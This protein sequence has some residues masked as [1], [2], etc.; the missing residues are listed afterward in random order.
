[1]MSRSDERQRDLVIGHQSER[2]TLEGF[3]GTVVAGAAAVVL[4]GPPGIGKSAL[5]S[6]GAG[7]SARAARVL[8][9]RPG[10]FET[11]LS[12]SGLEDLFNGLEVEISRL[13]SPQRQ[14]LQHALRI[15][16]AGSLM[17]DHSAV[18]IAATNTLRIAVAEG[19]LVIAV[20]D[21]QW[22]DASSARVLGFALRR[23]R[24]ESVGVLA[25]ARASDAPSLLVR[26]LGHDNVTLLEVSPLTEVETDEL[27]RVRLGAALPRALVREVHATA[28]GNPLF[29][30]ELTRAVLQHP[31]AVSTADPLPVP[32]SLRELVGRRLS[33]LAAPTRETVLIV[34][35]AARPTIETIDQALGRSS[36][37]A[38]Q[39]AVDAGLIESD[40]GHLRFTHPLLAATAYADADP[41]RRR[42]LHLRLAAAVKDVEERARQLA[43]GSDLPAA[44]VATEVEAGAA[45]ARARAAPEAAAALAEHALRLTPD[46]DPAAVYR[47]SLMAADYLWEAGECTR[48]EVVLLDLITQLP[49][50]AQRAEVL[51]RQ[52]LTTSGLH[53]WTA[54]H[55]LLEQA[56]R[57]ADDDVTLRATL[58]RDLAFGLMQT[59]DVR[60]A[61]SHVAAAQDLAELTGDVQQQAEAETVRTMHDVLVG[62]PAPSQLSQRLRQLGA[63]SEVNNRALYR[64]HTLRSVMA[65]ATLKWADDFD[66]ARSILQ[67]LETQLWGREEDGLLLPVLFQLGEL[68]CSSGRLQQAH[69]VAEL[70]RETCDRT[71][72]VAFRRCGSTY[73]RSPKLA[74]AWRMR[75]APS[76]RRA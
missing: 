24:G 47:R 29:A 21:L 9:T 71:G 11:K 12:Y 22:L 62:Y 6:Y 14:A 60:A 57:E 32:S 55:Q 59:G 30:L 10:E 42:R 48:S 39:R 33:A 52:A 34:A 28:A 40:R 56:L 17:T 53:S 45:A 76:P 2:A 26:A 67:R 8:M 15:M 16:D 18:A 50:G 35:M 49:P 43:A 1:M 5:W 68:E 7:V 37:S 73:G 72:L 65:A 74:P 75:L 25:T 63:P 19:P 4:E 61:T 23:L 58:E 20:D 70:G 27:I 51:R 13:A 46:D 64:G 69:S 54:A 31:H 66:G 41:V 3:V 44:E 36:A 38:V